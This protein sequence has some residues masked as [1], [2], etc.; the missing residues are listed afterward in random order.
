M[1]FP[2][3]IGTANSQHVPTWHT[4]KRDLLGEALD[5]IGWTR[6]DLGYRPEGYW[7]RFPNVPYKLPFFDSLFS[8]PMRVYDYTRTMGNAVERFLGPDYAPSRPDGVKNPDRLYQLIYFLSIERRVGGFRSYST[9]L[10][11]QVDD[12]EPILDAIRQIYTASGDQLLKTSFGQAPTPPT[13]E[14][15][16]TDQL[17]LA[18]VGLQKIIATCILD[19]LDARKWRDTALRRVPR[20]LQDKVFY[21]QDFA[22]TQGDGLDY[23][24]QVD[25]VAG[26]IDEQS[27]AYAAMKLG[28]T[29]EDTAYALTTYMGDH[30]EAG[31]FK[32]DEMT[33]Y[34]RI[35]IG[36]A[37]DDT[38][39]GDNYFLLIDLG[40]NNV[41]NCTAGATSS[42]DNGVSL[43][44][45]LSGNDKYEYTGPYPSQGAG[46]LGVGI[47]YNVKGNNT[48]KA[49]QMAQGAGFFG[50]GV[51][52]NGEGNNKCTLETNG[53]G[54]GCF[55]S[56][57]PDRRRRGRQ[58]LQ[59]IRRGPGIW[60]S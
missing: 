55:W 19:C 37:G 48:Y 33:P 42:P 56:R 44:I 6:A 24:P 4:D 9:N 57:T 26:L 31:A 47:L 28:Q 10:M 58:Q 16:I 1:L 21:I 20:E 46:V 40:G 53:Q 32:F 8:E 15:D 7:A 3:F 22:E 59:N 30:P 49:K 52:Y 13:P 34:G 17:K 18:D 23:Y 54:S 36:H 5:S 11:P 50:T 25:D 45:D 29:A 14:S 2:G 60:G 43:C 27:M 38:Y 41:F 51:L 12:K 35:T 39:T